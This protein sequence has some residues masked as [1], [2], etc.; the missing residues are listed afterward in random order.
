MA[1]T[2]TTDKSSD[3]AFRRL[4]FQRC[5]RCGKGAMFR[6]WFTMFGTCA[7]CGLS[8]ERERGFFLGAMYFNYMLGFPLLL[9]FTAIVKLIIL[10]EW[11]WHLAMFPAVLGLLLCLPAIFRYSRVLWIHLDHWVNVP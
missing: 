8:F 2:D 6:E 5:P 9:L 10:P 11:P 3:S 4:V 7:E 1:G